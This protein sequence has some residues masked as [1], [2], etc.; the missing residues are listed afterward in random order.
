MTTLFDAIEA[1]DAG[2]VWQLCQNG[3]ELGLIDESTG[4]TALAQAA[5]SGQL[6]IVRSLLDAG[7]DPDHGGVTT[8]LEA[9][10]VEGHAEIAQILIKAGADVNRAVED[11]FTP[12]MTAAATGDLLLVEALLGAGARPRKTN[13]EGHT[14][15]SL[16]R[17]A[18][19]AT[20]V[21]LLRNSRRRR[22]TAKKNTAK[23]EQAEAPQTEAA[24]AV[25][26]GA[27]EG[28][29][30]QGE[31]AQNADDGTPEEAVDSASAD[32]AAEAV[33][34]Q[35]SNDGADSAIDS[36]ATDSAANESPTDPPDT[37]EVEGLLAQQ[38]DASNDAAS[39]PDSVPKEAAEKAAEESSEGSEDQERQGRRKPRRDATS[40]DEAD[41]AGAEDAAP[42]VPPVENLEA[43]VEK[44]A[45]LAEKG[46][47]SKLG[48]AL[49][50]IEGGVEARDPEGRT[51]LMLAA[52]RGDVELVFWLLDQGADIEAIDQPRIGHTV[53]VHATQSLSP[54]RDKIIRRLVEAGADI[55]R[56]CGRRRRT[57][58]MHAADADVYLD[59]VEGPVFGNSTKTLIRLGARMETK[60]ARGNTVWQLIKKDAIG[61]P[62][63]GASRRRLHQML[64]VL[65]HG[66]AQPIASHAV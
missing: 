63:Y 37:S 6:E 28:D 41:D 18:G 20:I 16:A 60:D 34:A 57:P 40:Q 3:A 13:D 27:T 52:R 59:R 31:V 48:K 39:S 66:G 58:L 22:S 10:V 45:P 44:M 19:H 55:N 9:A 25:D 11:G 61:A 1:T 15:I 54:D 50:A 43:L 46:D 53:L 65:E 64:R 23:E 36:A 14:A 35:E 56:P 2:K 42:A 30:A 7:A 33:E 49:A 32:V 51:T 62:T 17:E 29:D 47:T 4:M 8:P 38:E 24:Q 21:T 12:L 26:N 5:E